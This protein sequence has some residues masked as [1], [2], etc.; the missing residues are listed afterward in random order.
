MAN[1]HRGEIDAVLDGE[2]RVLCLTLGALAELEAAFA[3]G[4]LA[5]LLKRF[6]ESALS[7]G[8]MIRIITAGLRGGGMQVEPEAV[9]AMRTEGGAT[10]FARIVA[11]L[12]HATFGESDPQEAP[13]NP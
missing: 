6:S 5:V 2:R 4:D 3:A 11:D 12:L 7:S 9:A 1:R 13:P 10:G 8:D